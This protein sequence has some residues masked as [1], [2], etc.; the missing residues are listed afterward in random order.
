MAPPPSVIK[1]RI[2]PTATFEPRCA[3]I[4]TV[5]GAPGAMQV[6]C[7]HHPHLRCLCRS[8]RQLKKQIKAQYGKQATLS[9]LADDDSKDAD[10][11][12]A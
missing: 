9:G 8:I 2:V 4:L 1:S 11:V 7:T 3:N 10:Q 12:T 6:G 5:T